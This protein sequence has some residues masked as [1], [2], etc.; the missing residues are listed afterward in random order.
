MRVLLLIACLAAALT[1]RVIPANAQFGGGP[2]SVGVAKVEQRPVTETSEF[3]GRIQAI[4][5]VDIVA[6]VTAFIEQRAF[7]EG[8][9]VQKGDLLY[10]LERG[11]FEADLEAKQAA[12][13]QN[14]GAAAQRHDHA[15]PRAEPAEHAGRA[16]G[17][18][19]TTRWR[20]SAASRR[21]CWRRR[22]SSDV[23]DQSRLHRNPRADRRQDQPHHADRRQRG[24]AR[25]RGAGHDRQPG[26]D[27]R[28][29]PDRRARRRWTCATAIADQG[30][31][32]A[33]G[34]QAAAA[35]RHDLRADRQARLRRSHGRSQ[36]RHR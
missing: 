5:R 25:D 8:A 22:R 11:P 15:E 36:H 6:R 19:S 7:I 1:A 29:V 2:P 23:A 14:A 3:V 13:A 31:F 28:A 17:R 32:D 33:R 27:V 35:G 30:G 9:E 16:S 20:S 21:S 10:R 18:P 34:D 12:V 4:D 24:D 26:P